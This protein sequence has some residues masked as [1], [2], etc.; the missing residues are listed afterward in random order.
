[1]TEQSVEWLQRQLAERVITNL[2]KNW[3][4]GFYFSSAEKA[5]TEILE[6]IPQG[7]TVGL[8][9][10][11]TLKQIGIIPMIE[12]GN[13]DLHN[14]WSKAKME[15]RVEMQRQILTSDVFVTGTNA[16]TL[17][18]ELVNIDGRG[19][20][21]AAMIFGPKKV[22]VV[23]GANKIV[24]NVDAAFERIK[25]IAGPLNSKQ[26]DFPK[27]RRPPCAVSG[28]CNDCKPPVTICCA[29]VVIRGQR[30]DRDRMKVFIIGSEL[31]F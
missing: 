7:A 4:S 12:K 10:S 26:H 17:N 25:S 27:E 31:G 24:R 1:M 21:V 19:N 13:Y 3:I 23:V 16:I 14:P 20:R 5:R 22:L 18:G 9:D 30:Q 28:F 15:E 8:G 29:Q 11:L 2:E 6:H